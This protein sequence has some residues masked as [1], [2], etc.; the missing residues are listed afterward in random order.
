M[1][2]LSRSMFGARLGPA[3]HGP[4]VF[5][6]HSFNMNAAK[7]AHSEPKASGSPLWSMAGRAEPGAER[8]WLERSVTTCFFDFGDSVGGGVLAGAVADFQHFE[9]I[10]RFDRS[11]LEHDAENAFTREDTIACEVVD[12]AP[13]VAHLA[14]LRD[15]DNHVFAD[16]DLGT[17]GHMHYVDAFGT[18]VLSEIAFFHIEPHSLGAFDGF[19]GK[20]RDLAMPIARG[21]CV[22]FHS[23]MRDDLNALGDRLFACSFALRD[24]CRTNDAFLA[25]FGFD[26]GLRDEVLAVDILVDID[27]TFGRG[28]ACA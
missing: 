6:F 5:M 4:S 20:K 10:A 15:L 23:E 27:R 21:V 12:G 1:F 16:F 3:R 2:R 24:A 25:Y 14:D 13:R 18:E 9:G 19:P 22:V 11:A 8:W 7:R 17:H 28:C 26:V